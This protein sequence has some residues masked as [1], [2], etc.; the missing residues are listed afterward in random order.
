MFCLLCVRL[1]DL[2][3]C[4]YNRTNNNYINTETTQ[5]YYR[6]H[7]H[8]KT[9]QQNVI[10]KTITNSIKNTYNNIKTCITTGVPFIWYF[11]CG[12]SRL[13]EDTCSIIVNYMTININPLVCTEIPYYGKE[14]LT[15]EGNPPTPL[16][17]KEFR[18]YIMTSLAI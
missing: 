10:N 6:K 5:T 3:F 13:Q 16:L 1:V 8:T 7:T 2:S 18:Y 17:Y 11:P 12:C 4:I 15:I 9:I 14:S